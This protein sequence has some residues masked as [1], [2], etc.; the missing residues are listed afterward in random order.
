MFMPTWS[1]ITQSVEDDHFRVVCGGS[2][3]RLSVLDAIS[4]SQSNG[5]LPDFHPVA[6]S[7]RHSNH[8]VWVSW[9]SIAD[10]RCSTNIPLS[11]LLSETTVHPNERINEL[12]P[13]PIFEP[14]GRHPRQNRVCLDLDGT[15]SHCEIYILKARISSRTD[16]LTDSCGNGGKGSYEA[17]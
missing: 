5:S 10:E 8:H 7:K 6:M 3:Y 16:D 17:K 9:V 4:D 11:T 1:W 14:I 15:V 12:N 2:V 13:P